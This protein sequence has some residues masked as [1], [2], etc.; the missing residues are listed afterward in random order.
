MDE[1]KEKLG[2]T[3]SEEKINAEINLLK[4]KSREMKE[5]T[6]EIKDRLELLLRESEK[7]KSR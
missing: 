4:Q 2:N 3:P 6:A 1:L 7:L 5:K